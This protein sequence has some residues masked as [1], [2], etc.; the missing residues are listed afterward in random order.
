MTVILNSVTTESS[1]TFQTVERKLK[2]K[3]GV[4]FSDASRVSIKMRQE[5]KRKER[6]QWRGPA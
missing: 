3:K 5:R 4:Q 2:K 6:E 1:G